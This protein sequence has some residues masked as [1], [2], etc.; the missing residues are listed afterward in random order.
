MTLNS[1]DLPQPDGPMTETN[2]PGL[3]L[4]DTSS[5]AVIGP[6]AVSKRTTI[7]STTTMGWP[8]PA[9]GAAIRLFAFARHPRGHG[10]GVAGLDAHIDDRD[11][12]GLDRGDGLGKDRRKIAYRIDRAE[13]LRSLRACDAGNVDVG[14]G[15]A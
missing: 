8:R 5:T 10:G 9:A 1:V 15:N 7:L 3:I 6:S 13:S 2:S 12:A 11:I 14:L 4:K